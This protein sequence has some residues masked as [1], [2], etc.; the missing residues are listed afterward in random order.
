VHRVRA[1][2]SAAAGA[3]TLEE[4]QPL[5]VPNGGFPE[6]LRGAV[7]RVVRAEHAACGHATAVRLPAEIPASSVRRVVCGGCSR[8]YEATRVLEMELVPELAAV[9]VEQEPTRVDPEPAVVAPVPAND[10]PEAA[11]EPDAVEES[12]IAEQPEVADSPK[13]PL[14]R[15]LPQLRRRA[16][17]RPTPG[18]KR[19]S[20]RLPR[21]ALPAVLT[22]RRSLPSIKRPSVSLP[23]P[24]APKVSLPSPPSWLHDP[25]S[26]GWRLLSIPL[27]AAAVIA[28]LMLIQG[29]S[30]DESPT[31]FADDAAPAAEVPAAGKEKP[32]D[33]AKKPDDASLIRESSFSLALP[34]RWERKGPTGG[35]TFAALSPEGDADATLWV[36]RDPNLSF[37]D[38][39]ARS[40]AQLETLAGSASVV[41]RVAAPTPEN[42]VVRLAADAPKGE[43]QFEVALRSAG[44]YRYY[45]ATTVQP[46][47][48]SEAI[49]G[50][51]LIQGSFVPTGASRGGG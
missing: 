13:R 41:E 18:P 15:R 26:R 32:G 28:A 33:A 8:A 1:R 12:E 43:A 37:A 30:G 4:I 7:V 22:E 31:P 2:Q 40:L 46:D 47:A 11:E 45:L 17:R 29:E 21:L 34:S 44:P 14:R 51:E 36:E 49:E 42:T 23:R 39:E 5:G 48:S 16:L 20:P 6:P 10:E 27:A 35:A 9:S 24:A 38:F 19:P 25:E 50:A 3:A